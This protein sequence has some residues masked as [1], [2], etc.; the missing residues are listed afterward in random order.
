MR[1]RYQYSCGQNGHPIVEGNIEK[2]VGDGSGEMCA[3][4]GPMGF[5]FVASVL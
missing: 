1:F 4:G 5:L 3:I 2:G